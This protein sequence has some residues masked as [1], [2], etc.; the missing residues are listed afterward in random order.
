M[1]CCQASCWRRS[2]AGLLGRVVQWH[3]LHSVAVGTSG[4]SSGFTSLCWTGL[5]EFGILSKSRI[6]FLRI[7]I[8]SWSGSTYAGVQPRWTKIQENLLDCLIVVWYYPVA[9]FHVIRN[10]DK[11][12]YDSLR[13]THRSAYKG[14][15]KPYSVYF[16]SS[17]ASLPL[18]SVTVTYIRV[19]EETRRRSK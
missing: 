3:S 19:K 16:C 12:S 15:K 14:T 10:T 1:P 7:L 17:T 6:T 9:P 5:Q 11:P 8:G 13:K 18:N 4:T 2:L